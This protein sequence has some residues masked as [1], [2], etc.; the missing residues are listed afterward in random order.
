M[1][2]ETYASEKPTVSKSIPIPKKINNNC[3]D[4]IIYYQQYD[5]KK[6]CFDPTKGSSPNSW[7]SRLMERIENYSTSS[8]KKPFNFII[9]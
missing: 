8:S 9:E 2:I 1:N 5:L 3:H 7:T 6:N 4:N